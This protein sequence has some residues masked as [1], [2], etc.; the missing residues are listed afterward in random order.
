M[1]I[2]VVIRQAQES[3]VYFAE[4][5]E[6]HVPVLYSLQAWDNKLL[7]REV[8]IRDK[9]I[10]FI[11]ALCDLRDLETVYTLQKNRCISVSR[12]SEPQPN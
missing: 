1:D 9:V 12:N 3:G 6:E 11:I 7:S 5:I 8:R 2:P 4:S 10:G